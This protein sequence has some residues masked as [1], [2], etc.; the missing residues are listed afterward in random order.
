M[1]LWEISVTVEAGTDTLLPTKSS[2]EGCV[3]STRRRKRIKGKERRQ[4]HVHTP[5]PAS[6]SALEV[7]IMQGYIVHAAEC[8][9]ED[10]TCTAWFQV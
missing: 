6:L 8:Q 10:E 1:H 5:K 2:Q 4:F 7:V 9:L 3:K